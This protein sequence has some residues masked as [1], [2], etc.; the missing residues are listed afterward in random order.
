MRWKKRGIMQ[1]IMNKNYCIL[2]LFF[3]LPLVALAQSTLDFR[4]QTSG[5]WT[6]ASTWQRFNGTTWVT[7]TASPNSSDNVITIRNGHTVT[8]SSNVGINQ[9]T[10]ELGGKLVHSNGTLTII[11]G[12]GTD[13]LIAGVYERTSTTNMNFSSPVAVVCANGGVYIHNVAGGSLP[14]ITWLDGS[15]LNIKNSITSGLDQSFW[16]VLIEGGMGTRLSSTQ[17]TNRTMTVRNNLEQTG[18]YFFLKTPVS[19]SERGGSH[20][21][22]VRGNI[23]HSGG[24]FS[25]NSDG[26]DNTSITSIMIGGNFTINGTADWSGFVNSTTCSSG[27]F[28]DG[29]GSQTFST[30][31]PHLNSTGVVRDRFFYKTSGGPTELHEIYNGTTAQETI[32]GSCGS[33]PPAG[34]SRWPTNGILLKTITI[35]NPAGVTLLHSRQV[36]TALYLKQGQFNNG[37]NLTMGDL[38]STIDRSGGNLSHAALGTSY[39]VTYSSYSTGYATGLE[40]PLGETVLQTLTINNGHQITVAPEHSLLHI[41]NNLKIES[42]NFQVAAGYRVVLTNSFQNTGG[43][44]TFEN[45]SSLIQISNNTNTGSLTYKRIAQ[46]RNLDYVYWSSPTAGYNINNHASNGPKYFWNTTVSNQNGSQG[47]W[48]VAAGILPLGTGV[49]VRGPSN[50]NNT[51]AQNLEN[52]FIGVPNNGTISVNVQRGSIQSPFFVPSTPSDILVTELDDNWNLIGNPYPSAISAKIFLQNNQSVLTDGLFIWTHGILPS[53]SNSNPF[54]QNFIYNYSTNDYTIY[55]LSGSLLG[56]SNDYYIGAGQGF[57]VAMLDG[58]AQTSEVVFSNT[59]RNKNYGNATGQQFFR[60]SN[61]PSEALE[62]RYWLDLVKDSTQSSRNLIAYVN[63]A[64]N[65]R[66]PLYDAAATNTHNQFQLYSL[67]DNLEFKIQ[68]RPLNFV[69][70]DTVPL[71]VTT[72]DAGFY[73]LALAAVDGFFENDFPIYLHDKLMDTYHNLQDSYYECYLQQGIIE[74][75]FEIVYQQDLLQVN[76]NQIDKVLLFRDQQQTIHVDCPTNGLEEITVF[77]LLGKTLHHEVVLFKPETYELRGCQESFIIV[78]IKYNDT[79]KTF[80]LH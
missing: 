54:Y 59:Q 38:P 39:N 6:T 11:D 15:L 51:T 21:L 40:I 63:G 56:P 7:A 67:I 36:N 77:N 20:V 49:I 13:L 37:L 48:Q 23:L 14:V 45:N 31:L 8:V 32:S 70:S 68:G 75:R 43:T 42:G 73:K 4:S 19:S 79:F 78:R 30:V 74:D 2:I 64:T 76:D 60:T 41:N 26:Q 62:G 9:T 52:T 65:D 29:S 10:V 28:F 44:A 33:S 69:L 35:D 24:F 58:P 55:N 34:Y 1:I 17:T 53:Q 16:N 61:D 46:Q 18:G 3:C 66:D 5:N 25:W 12:A 50:Y 27:I 22:N 57:M 47:N 72:T 80:K 71:G